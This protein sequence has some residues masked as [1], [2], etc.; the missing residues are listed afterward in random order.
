MC[1][2]TI[3]DNMSAMIRMP[4]LVSMIAVGCAL[5]LLPEPAEARRIKVQAIKKISLKQR[6]DAPSF[7]RARRLRVMDRGKLL[8]LG[9]GLWEDQYTFHLLKLEDHSRVRVLSPIK[10]FLS[11]EPKRFPG[12]ASWRGY[13]VGP[14]LFLDSTN[15]RAGVLLRERRRGSE[16]RVF[17]L[18]WDLKKKEITGARLLGKRS[19]K[20]PY[21]HV[22]AVGYAP[23][24]DE[25]YLQVVR[26]PPRGKQGR[27]LSVVALRAGKVRQVMSKDVRRRLSSGPFF[28]AKHNRA[29]LVAYAEKGAADPAP[30][31]YLV[32]LSSGKEAVLPMRIPLTT[33]GAS[34]SPDGKILHAYSAQT[35]KIS[36]LDARTGKRLRRVHVGQLG[37]ALGRPFTGAL[38]VVRNK[39]LSFLREKRLTRMQ[40]VPSARIY[41]G[42]SHVQGSLV[43]PQVTAVKNR[44]T[45]YV[46]AFRRSD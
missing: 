31:G 24:R 30:M 41:T 26:A 32:Q 11:S 44:E 28:D 38:L 12:A 36:A 19:A 23:D 2:R 8:S 22:R 5:L 4:I 20:W 33:Y 37:H 45:L 40:F 14:L 39:G 16:Q 13:R 25:L 46:L 21:L 9:T 42:Y 7:T 1:R 6:R 43:T 17:Y 10:A 18:R 15:Q 29:L 34:F 3:Y 27:K 35:G